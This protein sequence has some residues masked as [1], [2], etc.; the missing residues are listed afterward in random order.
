MSNYII[1]R[2]GYNV[3]VSSNNKYC[4]NG[5]I[6]HAFKS[7]VKNHDSIEDDNLYNGEQVRRVSVP[8]P[9]RADDN[10]NKNV[11]SFHDE[12]Q[13]YIKNILDNKKRLIKPDYYK[14]LPHMLKADLLEAYKQKFKTDF[15][16]NLIS[17]DEYND[18][19]TELDLKII[20]E[21]DKSEINR[22]EKKQKKETEK[23]NKLI[24]KENIKL[25]KMR[26]KD[27]YVA[28]GTS[29]PADSMT[30]NILTSIV[31]LFLFLFILGLN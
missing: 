14:L 27:H 5:D 13:Q 24:D 19:I 23:L 10:S 17:E 11:L 15:K 7:F 16:N 6:K 18:V 1:R 28:S 2:H 3:P 29:P 21:I 20:K 31:A 26:D 4:D 30:I 8:F 9:E 25:Q 12:K 22:E